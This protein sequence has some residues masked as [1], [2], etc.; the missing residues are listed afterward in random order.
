MTQRT[1][2]ALLAGLL[3]LYVLVAS[4]Y[5]VRTPAWQ[6]PDE[7][8]HYNYI[9]QVASNGCCPVIEPGDWDQ[10]YL[11][12]LTSSHFAPD[13]LDRLSAL[14]YEDHQPPLYYLLASVVYRLFGGSLLALR[15]FSVLIGAGVV[16]SAYA[17]GRAALPDRPQ[18]ALGAAVVVAFIPQHIAGLASVNNDGLA[19]LIIGVTLWALLVY[20]RTPEHVRTPEGVR[21]PPTARRIS[22]W[23]LG[24][25]VGVGLLTKVSTLFL[26]G[27][28]PLGITLHALIPPRGATPAPS[29][30]SRIRRL[31]RLDFIA[32]AV[33]WL[34]PALL[35]SGVWWLRDIG[36]Y[37]FP[38]LFGLGRHN[39]VVADQPRTADLIA[40]VG[41]GDYLRRAVETTFNSFWG[42][43]G[44]MAL[45]IPSW[46][47][48]LILALLAAVLVGWLVA[49]VRPADGRIR[50][51][52]FA[53]LT[54]ERICWL[55]LALTGALA[56]AQFLYYNSE[57]LQLQGRYM[58]TGLIPF[59]LF[60]AIGIDALWS[61]VSRSR[62]QWG[63]ALT[64]GVFFVAINLFLVWRVLPL[65][66]P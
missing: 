57:F 55:L 32:I 10:A 47:Y 34:L 11:N 19:E 4:A 25:L 51:T 8:A 44:W 65:L 7:P 53:L 61:R 46:T 2:Y 33:S 28:V 40:Q 66:A 43:F 37:G 13:Q 31:F 5:A 15:L 36:V 63:S 14:Q 26:A 58:F 20:V 12:Q 29:I 18:I 21:T 38:D 23:M 42:Q 24:I 41:V 62:L 64:L 48:L 54:P 50:G 49:F 56:V 3:A 1:E 45:P 22:P 16:A 39:L 9:A 6:S 17:V 27:L 35:L 52:P 59:G 60:V 30:A